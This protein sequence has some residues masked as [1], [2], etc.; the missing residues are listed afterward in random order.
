M[1]IDKIMRKV[2]DEVGVWSIGN[3]G[4]RGTVC[5]SFVRNGKIVA[6]RHDYG[7]IMPR[8]IRIGRYIQSIE[9][10]LRLTQD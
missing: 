6:H 7:G 9:E 2:R 4:G 8:W 10:E 5:V 3:Y 1:K